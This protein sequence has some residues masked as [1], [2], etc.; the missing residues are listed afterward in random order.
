M[1]FVK[2][3]FWRDRKKATASVAAGRDARV[4]TKEMSGQVK[5]AKEVVSAEK[6]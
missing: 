2:R 5:A 6:P 4:M 3:V 1:S